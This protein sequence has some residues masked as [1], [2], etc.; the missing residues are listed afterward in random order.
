MTPVRS[1][2]WGFSP[3]K[4]TKR[5]P[6]DPT[7]ALALTVRLSL[8]RTLLPREPMKLFAFN[9]LPLVPWKL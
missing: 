4:V 2:S 6:L 7:K 5:L 1:F 8:T 3:N 9:L